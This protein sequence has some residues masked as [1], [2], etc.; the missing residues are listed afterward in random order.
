MQKKNLSF[1]NEKKYWLCI[2]LPA[3][4]K[5]H[6]L[7][8]EKLNSRALP[9]FHFQVLTTLFWSTCFSFGQIPNVK[10]ACP[11]LVFFIHRGDLWDFSI[12]DE[13]NFQFSSWDHLI[14][15]RAKGELCNVMTETWKL[16]I[17]WANWNAELKSPW[18]EHGF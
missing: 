17:L 16:K 4:F 6:I 3:R 12:D 11:T 13:K 2:K 10:T 5:T 9:Y 18:M 8:R 15:E 7:F 1:F 14:T